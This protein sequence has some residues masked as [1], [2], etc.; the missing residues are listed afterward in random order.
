MG[1]WPWKMATTFDAKNSITAIGLIVLVNHS[2][3]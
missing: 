3:S 2:V 1:I